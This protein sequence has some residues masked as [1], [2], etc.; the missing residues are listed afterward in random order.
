MQL[1]D[2]PSRKG[3]YRFMDK[4]GQ[5]WEVPLVDDVVLTYRADHA[6][7]RWRGHG[8]AVCGENSTPMSPTPSDSVAGRIFILRGQRKLPWAFTE[9]G[10]LMAATVLNSPRVVQMSLYV[11]RAFVQMREALATNQAVLRRLAEIDKTLLD[12]DA[13][14]LALWKKLQPLPAPPPEPPRKELGFHTGMKKLK[15]CRHGRKEHQAAKQQRHE[16]G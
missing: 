1:C 13:A 14:L 16:T 12:H 11:I 10:C 15:R 7:S 6:V 4:N 5:T 8:A 9:H 3:D 2:T